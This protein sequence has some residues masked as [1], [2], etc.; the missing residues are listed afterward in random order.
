MDRRLLPAPLIGVLTV[1]AMFLW[2][3]LWGGMIL[4]PLAILKILLP[5]P[6]LRRA[7][8]R[9]LVWIAGVPWVRG[10]SAIYT[11]LHGRRSGYRLDP[12]LDPRRSWLI[13]SNHQS[14]ADILILF[15]AFGGRV[16]FPRFFLKKELIWV[17]LVGFICWALDMP[18]MKRHSREAVAANPALKNQDLETTRRFCEKYKR[19][20][21][22]VVNFVEGTR[23]SPAK[24][25]AR[26]SPYQH[27]LRPK[28]AGLSFMLNAMGEQFAGL[29]D[30][31]LVYQ[32]TNQS[33]LWSFLCGEQHAVQLQA[34][35]LQL[36]DTLLHG[37]Y[38]DDADYRTRFQDWVNQLWA[39]KDLELARL[40]SERSR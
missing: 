31:T 29:I 3:M 4:L 7:L 19:Q 40:R 11:L 23:S 6:P 5:A 22:T 37:D 38:S 30:V 21:I 9:A 10:N 33:K 12:A 39:D 2:L 28:S 18:F 1:L 20:P 24:R 25:L 36:P 16:P 13:V 8:G 14:W 15:D 34:R 17:P 27:L 32:T 35:V 26:Q